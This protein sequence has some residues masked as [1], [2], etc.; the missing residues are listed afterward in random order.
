MVTHVFGRF[1]LLL[2]KI[3]VPFMLT[4]GLSC[5]MPLNHP[6]GALIIAVWYFRGYSNVAFTISSG[7]E[8]G[9]HTIIELRLY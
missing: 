4:G 6:C 1:F 2:K 9:N 5:C 3:P 8:G 7:D